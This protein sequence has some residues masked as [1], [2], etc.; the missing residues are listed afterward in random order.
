MSPE[1][2]VVV[3]VVVATPG[4][5]FV[6][7]LRNTVARGRR[8]GTATAVGVGVGIGDTAASAIQV[9]GA[10]SGRGVTHGRARTGA[11][12]LVCVRRRLGRHCVTSTTASANSTRSP[13]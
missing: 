10:A 5:D 3:L 6:V 1:F 2:F 12:S 7:T 11:T 9:L 8:A 13:P 4:A